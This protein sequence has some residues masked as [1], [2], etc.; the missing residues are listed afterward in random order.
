MGN[1][2]FTLTAT[3]IIDGQESSPSEGASVNITLDC[4]PTITAPET[5]TDCEDF[6]VSGTTDPATTQI[7]LYIDGNL[8]TS[9]TDIT[10]GGEGEPAT[11]EIILDPTDPALG[12]GDFTLTATAIIDGQESS[13]SEGASVNITLDCPPTITAP[14]T[15]TDCEDFTVS[16]TTD[17]ATTQINLY[18]D[19]NLFTSTTDITPGG[20]GEPAT[21]EIILDPTDP[22]LGNGDFTL[23]ATAIIDGQESS[24]SEGASVNITLDCPPTITAPETVTDCEDFT[25]S[26]TADPATTQINLYIDGNLFTSTTDITPGGEGEPATW[27]IIL[28]PT[29]PALGNGDFTL[30]ATAIIDGQESSP[31]EG[32][33]VNITLDCPP[34]ITAPET[35]TDCEDFTVSGTTDPATTQINL[36]IDGNLFTSTTDITPGGEGE[37]AT[38]E[39]I[40]DPTDPALGNGDFT[41]TATAII[42]GQESSPSEGASVNI[43]L[44]CPPTITAPETV[45]DCEDFTVSGTTDPATTQINLYID[46]NL[47]TSTTDITPG[48]EGEPAT[49]EIILDPTDPALGNGD[50]TLTAT[51]IIDGQESSPSEGASVNITLDCPPTITAPETVTD[52]EDFT[53]SGTTILLPHK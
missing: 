13:P 3:A 53:V 33:S 14:E 11:W 16:G 52:C 47:F 51:A 24:P 45:T 1:G 50:F 5:V 2:D 19:G 40:L 21:W 22:A 9:T 44:D 36:Y 4:P 7:N 30:T 48:G 6:T 46:G 41:L 20:E 31:S 29:D 12:N 25:V 38:W 18:I 49:W 39:I 43:T 23:T 10:P 8:F 17:P 42:D 28:D 35:V 34:T 26:G 37:P 27:E 32:A 15:V